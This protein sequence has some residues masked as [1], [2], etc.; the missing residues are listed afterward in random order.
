MG[1]LRYVHNGNEASGVTNREIEQPSER[2]GQ[3]KDMLNGVGRPEN[4][5]ERSGPT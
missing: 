4:K 3:G 2:G 1:R 5:V